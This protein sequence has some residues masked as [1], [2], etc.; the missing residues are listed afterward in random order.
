LERKKLAA[1]GQG[2]GSVWA[3]TPEGVR[4]L[5]DIFSA[6]DF[7][8][9]E[10]ELSASGSSSFGHTVHPVIPPTLAPPAIVRPVLEFIESHP[11]DTNVFAMTRFPSEKDVKPLKPAI[12]AARL[13]LQ[14]QGLTLH[15]ASD[16]AIIDDLWSN[17]TAYMWASRYGI[18]FF[19]DL[20][21][22]GINSNMTIEVG[23]MLVTGRRCA[24]LRDAS[25]EKMPTDLVGHIYK[26]VTV[27]S[28]KTVGEAVTDWVTKDVRI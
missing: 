3:P 21:G 2:S 20:D 22:R 28:P 19:E 1:R 25:V 16:G 18:A 5:D 27:T 23:G 4:R 11:F 26:R 7:L 9:L 8:S 12:E 10:G 14:A 17:V 13:A 6:G 24:L 15:L